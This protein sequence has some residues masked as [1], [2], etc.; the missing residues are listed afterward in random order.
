M[1]FLWFSYD[2]PMLFP[3]FSYG[4]ASYGDRSYRGPVLQAT[5]SYKDECVHIE[6]VEFSLVFS[7][8][9]GKK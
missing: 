9:L 8:L 1:I 4:W 3:W 7:T 2:F 5:R 6:N